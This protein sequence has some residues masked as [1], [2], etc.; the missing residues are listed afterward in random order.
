MDV[1][2]L[3]DTIT[4]IEHNDSIVILKHTEQDP[5]FAPL[6]QSVLA[7]IVEL[8][9]ER[10]RSDATIG[11]VLILVSSPGRITPYHMDS[12]TNFLLQIT[13]D[14]WFHIFDHC[15]SHLGDGPGARGLLLDQQELRGL[16]SGA[17][18]RLQQI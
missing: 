17:P 1:N 16:P 12:E 10:M 5:V 8:A 4:H 18:R 13:G 3:Q 11:E 15:G 2:P 9:G 7:T 14:K 6:L